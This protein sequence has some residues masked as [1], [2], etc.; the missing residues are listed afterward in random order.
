MTTTYSTYDAKTHFSEVLRRVRAGQRIRIT[1][2]GKEVAEIIPIAEEERGLA[3]RI[4]VL[5]ERERLSRSTKPAE[6]WP[7]AIRRPG[8]LSRFLEER[9]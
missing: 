9:E 5:E 6:E 7:P 8:A 2:H 4:E 1:H 3:A